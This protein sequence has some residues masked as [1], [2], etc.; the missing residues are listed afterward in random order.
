MSCLSW[1]KHAAGAT[2]TSWFITALKCER[3]SNNVHHT[4]VCFTTTATGPH[5][6]G[7]LNVNANIFKHLKSVGETQK[8]A[9]VTLNATKAPNSLLLLVTVIWNENTKWCTAGLQQCSKGK[10]KKD[11]F[12]APAPLLAAIGT[13]SKDK[14]KAYLQANNL[15]L[16]DSIIRYGE[17][18]S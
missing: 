11:Y 4:E 15:F 17:R 18:F 9:W 1:R 14:S 6:S 8:D 12:F 3:S 10:K 16:N 2:I 7:F 13:G 5:S